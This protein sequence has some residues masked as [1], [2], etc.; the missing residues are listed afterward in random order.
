MIALA[1]K[2]NLL[3]TD[4]EPFYKAYLDP[5]MGSYYIAKSL[6]E[7]FLEGHHPMIIE[8]GQTFIEKD[9]SY[10]LLPSLPKELI[11]SLF[12]KHRRQDLK[13]SRSKIIQIAKEF[14]F[15]HNISY[16]DYVK[17]ELPY[18]I[19]NQ[20]NFFDSHNELFQKGIEFSEKILKINIT[21]KIPT[22]DNLSLLENKTKLKIISLFKWTLK[23]RANGSISYEY[24]KE[25][26][27]KYLI[28]LAI[29][30]KE[31][32]PQIRSMFSNL[33]GT[34]LSRYLYYLPKSFFIECLSV[35][36][37]KCN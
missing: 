19:L 9:L 8:Y 33:S 13:I 16:F 24:F 5:D 35:L 23:I 27:T 28:Q 3:K 2:W 1:I 7:K 22:K 31:L 29:E 21:P 26:L 17:R 20:K 25:E 15:Y 10:N 12:L 4:F 34:P 30:K 36:N 14:K 32:F 6:S 18:E 11:R 37:T